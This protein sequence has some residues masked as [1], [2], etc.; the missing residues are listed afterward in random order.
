[1]KGLAPV[2][3]ELTTCHRADKA[4]HE[5]GLLCR[6]PENTLEMLLAEA[7][8]L[9]CAASEPDICLCLSNVHRRA[10]N[11]ETNTRMKPHD[12]ILLD[13]ADGPMWLC[14]GLKLIGGKND[15]AIL[16]DCWYHITDISD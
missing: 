3:I 11:Q 5:Y 13:A 16:N 4:L 10:M 15:H 7:R 14:K 2:M 6:N 12:A 8:S 1:M 9:F